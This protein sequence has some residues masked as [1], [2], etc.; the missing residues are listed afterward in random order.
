MRLAV[1][2]P[3]GMCE[4]QA[5]TSINAS[6]RAVRHAAQAAQR[7]CRAPP[8][9]QQL[10]A[11]QGAGSCT[12]SRPATILQAVIAAAAAGSVPA[13]IAAAAIRARHERKQ[14]VDEA[15]SRPRHIPAGLLLFRLLL[16]LLRLL[17]L[18]GTTLAGRGVV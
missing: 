15:G 18:V 4:L 16:S 2:L 13:S 1:R 6:T 9:A 12:C 17:L 10:P 8:S 7:G 5:S 14:R 3:D 11:A